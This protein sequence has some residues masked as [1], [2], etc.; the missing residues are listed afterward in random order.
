M[1]APPNRRGP[2]ARAGKEWERLVGG[3]LRHAGCKFN[4]NSNDDKPV[5]DWRSVYVGGRSILVECK[6]T[7]QDKLEFRVISGREKEGE[8]GNLSRHHDAGG[9]TLVLICQVSGNSRKAW[10]VWWRD[11]LHLEDTIG[12]PSASV[13]VRRTGHVRLDPPPQ[14]FIALAKVDRGNG[15]GSTWDLGPVL[16]AQS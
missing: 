1:S 12:R 8:F 15:L 13:N 4:K 14:C 6:E 16:A 2:R 11:W 7:E 5:C 10:A 9:L 3:I